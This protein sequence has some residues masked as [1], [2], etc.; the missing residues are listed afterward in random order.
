MREQRKSQNS[1]GAKGE[2]GEGE[3][4]EELRSVVREPSVAH[5]GRLVGAFVINHGL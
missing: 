1:E 4:E 2:V 5:V 3:G